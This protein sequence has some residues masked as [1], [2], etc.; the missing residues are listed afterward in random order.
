MFSRASLSMLKACSKY[1]ICPWMSTL[2][3]SGHT[4]DSLVLCIFNSIV[5][6]IFLTEEMILQNTVQVFC[7][8]E[9]A[10][11]GRQWERCMWW[12]RKV[13]IVMSSRMR[14]KGSH[15]AIG[16]KHSC[17][18]T[19][20]FSE[21][22]AVGQRLPC[23]CLAPVMCQ[24]AQKLPCGCLVKRSACCCAAMANSGNR[25]VQ[26]WVFPVGWE[27]CRNDRERVRRGFL[28]VQWQG[29]GQDVCP[30]EE[31]PFGIPQNIDRWHNLSKI[32]ATPLIF[33]ALKDK[34]T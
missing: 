30:K 27:S 9:E 29:R 16:T 10:T 32:W 13:S 25:H 3:G 20:V 34:G 1:R 2:L 31:N 14:L 33:S 22:L 12:G 26:V 7:D 17:W 8:V 18:W 15:E 5:M 4:G 11:L 23:W 28:A 24:G 21:C 19:A 6:G